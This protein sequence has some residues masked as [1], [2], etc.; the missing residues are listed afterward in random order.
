MHYH[1]PSISNG[2]L[3]VVKLLNISSG[4]MNASFMHYDASIRQVLMQA[5]IYH[6]LMALEINFHAH[7]NKY[8][9]LIKSGS[10]NKEAISISSGYYM[11][12]ID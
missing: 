5:H 10:N 1:E 2:D 12:P 8:H 6:L 4:F 11:H 3:T 7:S 9:S